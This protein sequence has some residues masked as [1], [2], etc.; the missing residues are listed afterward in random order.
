MDRHIVEV[1]DTPLGETNWYTI[2]TGLNEESSGQWNQE[3]WEDL[4]EGVN[5]KAIDGSPTPAKDMQ[6]EIKKDV[7]KRIQTI[8]DYPGLLWNKFCIMWGE[9]MTVVDHLLVSEVSL[10]KSNVLK[11]ICNVFYYCLIIF[12]L[13][14]ACVCFKE[15]NSSEILMIVLYGIGLMLAH[16]LVEV[17]GRYHYSALV[18]FIIMG[19]YGVKRWVELVKR[20]E[21]KI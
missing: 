4:L 12:S 16:L 17:Q 14:A 7:E 21:G 5:E 11:I 1:I 15:N 3:D 20:K 10:P 13:Y 18:V 19:S 8:K 6:E 2:N 9:D